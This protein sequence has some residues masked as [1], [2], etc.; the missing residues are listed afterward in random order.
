M[1]HII[2]II[3]LYIAG[4]I[5]SLMHL[6]Y[7]TLQ[8]SYHAKFF[9]FFLEVCNYLTYLVKGNTKQI[10]SLILFRQLKCPNYHVQNYE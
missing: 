4:G 1:T 5:F 8:K 2:H 7:L 6:L 10:Q 3:R 9:I